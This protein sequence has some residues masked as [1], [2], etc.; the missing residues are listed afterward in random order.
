VLQLAGGSSLSSST[1]DEGFIETHIILYYEESKHGILRRSTSHWY[2]VMAYDGSQIILHTSKM[3]HHDIGLV[4]LYQATLHSFL[5][6]FR[7]TY[8]GKLLHGYLVKEFLTFLFFFF[9]LSSFWLYITSRCRELIAKD[10][11]QGLFWVRSLDQ[12]TQVQI[13]SYR[14][15]PTK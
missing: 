9:F 13:H 5:H 4:S 12:Y 7:S 11:S 3:A 8:S 14:S 15:L 2:G 6:G 10:F 1:S